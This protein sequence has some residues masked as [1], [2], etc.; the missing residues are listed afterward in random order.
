MAPFSKPETVL[1]QADG[2]ISVGQHEAALQSLTEMFASK[3]FRNTPLV[4][5]EPIVLRFISLCV[6]L[7]QGRTAKEGLMQYKNIAQNTSVASI[8]TVIKRFLALCDAKVEEA[9]EKANKITGLAD[10]DDLEASETPESILLG[11]VSGDQNKDRTDRALVTPWLKFLW[12]AYRTALE[13]LKNNNRLEAIYQQIVH[14]AFKFCLKHNRR[15][16]FRRLCETLRLHLA[17]VAKYS[18]Q[19]HSINLSDPDTL[20][21]HLDARFAQLNTSVELELWQE[22]FRSVEDV[23]NLLTMAKKAPRPAMMANYYEKLARIFLM[24][25]SALFHAAA[26]GRYYS[27]I[28][29]SAPK[30]EEEVTTLAGLVLVSALAVPISAEAN[31][32][33]PEEIKGRNARL[34]SLLGLTKMPTRSSLLKEALARNMLKMASEPIRQLYQIL[35]ITFHPLT[36]CATIAPVLQ[37]LAADPTYSPYLPLLHKVLLSRLFGQLSQVYSSVKISHILDLVAPLNAGPSTGG[38][39]AS[40]IHYDHPHIEAFVMACAKRGEMQVR[41]DHAQGSITFGADAF[42]SSSAASSSP[43]SLIRNRLTRLAT[44]LTTSL[45]HLEPP[46]PAPSQEEQQDAFKALVEQLDKEKKDLNERLRVL[47]RRLDHTERAFRK[48]EKSLLAEDYSRQQE[49]DKKAYEAYCQTTRKS[50]EQGHAD[51]LQAKKRL[52]RMM[53]DYEDARK[54]IAGKKEEELQERKRKARAKIDAEKA[55]RRERIL[56]EREEERRRV[57][58]EERE[59]REKEEEE[60]RLARELEEEEERK[61]AEAEA[62]KKAEEE[63]RQEEERSREATRKARE[64]ERQKTLEEAKRRQ[65]LEEEAEARRLARRTQTAANAPTDNV[66]RPSR[67]A[68]ATAASSTSPSGTPR[69]ASPALKSSAPPPRTAGSVYRPPGA[70]GAD[71]S[72]SHAP[73]STPSPQPSAPP[74]IARPG[75]G[76]GWR[77]RMAAKEAHANGGSSN[78]RD[79]PQ[80][81]TPRIGSPKPTEDEDG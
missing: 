37:S 44:A 71:T 76:G 35:E 13:T 42:A 68:G 62:A 43:V 11:A 79:S 5:L 46:V 8:E 53:Q 39:G 78:G 3:K 51:A 28:R 65:K 22:A 20:Q 45:S 38:E 12:E 61:R 33:A 19:P 1:K 4:S 14:Q 34:T 27:T 69:P 70:R 21:S 73:P 52:L 36:I 10:V 48:E 77:E 54:V 32:D 60:A 6:D 55:K 64:E 25:G 74:L 63:K 80:P 17:N 49:N 41:V 58:E 18:H 75:G 31:D 16:E 40:E 81:A 57:E 67:V 24:S 30:T 9:Q 56:R 23:H 72:S 15:V 2:L 50:A 7:R 47:A 59:R 26:W 66:W 29:T